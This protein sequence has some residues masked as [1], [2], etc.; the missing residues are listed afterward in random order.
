M[1]LHEL[2]PM[3]K[4]TGAGGSVTTVGGQEIAR[5]TPKI[6]GLQTTSYADGSVKQTYQTTHN[7]GDVNIKQT[8]VN[9][10]D[11]AMDIDSGAISIGTT[12][13]PQNPK[14]NRFK[15]NMGAGVTL[16]AKPGSATITGPQGQ[17]RTFGSP[18]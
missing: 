12:G 3:T 2:T 16:S 7:T 8:K 18:R 14:V 15:A 11:V 1:R 4:R 13:T 5:S 9:G 10:K 6:G 17:K